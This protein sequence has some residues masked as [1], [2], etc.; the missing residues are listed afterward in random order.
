LKQQL[1]PISATTTTTI[2]LCAFIWHRLDILI[3]AVATS[4][5]LWIGLWMTTLANRIQNGVGRTR[6]DVRE[7]WRLTNLGKLLDDAGRPIEDDSLTL[8]TPCGDIR[9]LPIDVDGETVLVGVDESAPMGTVLE[10]RRALA[11]DDRAAQ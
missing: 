10:F 9:P 8:P 2:A 11:N 4:A 7:G 6:A 3:L 1:L 5:V